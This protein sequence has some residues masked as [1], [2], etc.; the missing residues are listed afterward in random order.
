MEMAQESA[1][2][3]KARL[4]AS[5]PLPEIG[6]VCGSGCGAV[7]EA[8]E[9][10]V[11]LSFGEIPHFLSTTVPGHKGGSEMGKAAVKWIGRRGSRRR[12]RG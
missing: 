9:N 4:P 10:P 1:A 7:A 8:V 6:V 3:I 2:F 5:A 12:R 11:S